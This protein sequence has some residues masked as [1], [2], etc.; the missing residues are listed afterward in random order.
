MDELLLKELKEYRKEI[1]K[2]C[3]G[4]GYATYRFGSTASPDFYGDEE[5][6]EPMRTHI[7]FCTCARGKQ[8]R[9]LLKIRDMESK[10]DLLRELHRIIKAYKWELTN[11]AVLRLFKKKWREI[12]KDG[13]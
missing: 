7:V 13:K 12:Q 2:H 3:R 10:M 5:Y 4:K 11:L 9:E 1:C 8:L 6:I